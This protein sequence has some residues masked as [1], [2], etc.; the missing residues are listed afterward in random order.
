[1]ADVRPPRPGDSGH[2]HDV[3]TTER[4]DMAL[5][6]NGFSAIELGRVVRKRSATV[7]ATAAIA[8]F[9][10]LGAQGAAAETIKVANT[11]DSGNGSLRQAINLA[12]HL[13]GSGLNRIVIEA[14]GTIQL[15]SVLPVLSTA[16]TIQGPGAGHLSVDGSAV[17]QS[18]ILRNDL[19]A[20]L[21][22]LSIVNGPTAIENNGVLSVARTRVSDNDGGIDSD[23]ALS[24][25]D[26]RMV[27]N[28]DYGIQNYNARADVRR[29]T[30]RDNGTGILN[31]YEQANLGVAQSTLS[32]NG[33]G[34]LNVLGT[35]LIHRSTL[36]GNQVTA[37]EN[38]LC[39][40]GCVDGRVTVTQSTLSGNASAA[41]VI[42]STDPATTI[43]RSTI[44]ASSPSWGGCWDPDGGPASVVS[45]GFNL[46]DDGSCNLTAPSDQPDTKPLLR[47]LANYGGPTETLA[48]K[49]ASPAIDAGMAG[50]V[51]TDQRG[52]P[53]IVDFPGVPTAVGDNSDV[54][55]FELQSP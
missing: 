53:R 12:N 6:D 3:T 21:T 52:L 55:A 41:V 44:V 7:I 39:F 33:T 32:T 8:A 48:L 20:T 9:G 14:T 43:L 51:T 31:I 23:G 17:S 15:Q 4:F 42:A 16:M 13:P 34:I 26:S 40:D 30:L 38:G 46:A 11:S 1:M 25:A 36:S 28:R 22:G 19:K 49:A 27:G 2:I 5:S 10:V 37:V 29:S 45:A 54:G 35:A 18:P 24:V 50:A 47:P